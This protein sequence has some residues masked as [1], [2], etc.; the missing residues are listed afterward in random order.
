MTLSVNQ[1]VKSQ[2][3]ERIQSLEQ[4]YG[5]AIRKKVFCSKQDDISIQ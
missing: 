4:I 3:W 1:T 5:K 2:S